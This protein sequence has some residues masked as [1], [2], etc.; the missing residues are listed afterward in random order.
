MNL[1][2]IILAI[3]GIV[4]LTIAALKSE[5][6][7][8]PRDVIRG[9]NLSTRGEQDGEGDYVFGL[10]TGEET[11]ITPGYPGPER[12]SGPLEQRID[13]RAKTRRFLSTLPYDPILSS[14]PSSKP[15]EGLPNDD[16]P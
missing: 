12:R 9:E 6:K 7:Q 10:D 1:V 16:Y 14:D 3:A 11:P 2:A 8:A 4:C 5:K 13:E 15:S